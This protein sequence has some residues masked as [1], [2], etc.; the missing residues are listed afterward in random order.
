MNFAKI[1]FGFLSLVINS[2][3]LGYLSKRRS[4]SYIINIKCFAKKS[5]NCVKNMHL[6][7][8]LTNIGKNSLC[9]FIAV[10]L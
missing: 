7:G 4:G 2:I 3:G 8:F 9:I 1:F 6:I 5:N 10:S